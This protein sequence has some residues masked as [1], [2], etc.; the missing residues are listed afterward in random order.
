MEG[1]SAGEQMSRATEP[2]SRGSAGDRVRLRDPCRRSRPAC[3]SSPTAWSTATARS[4]PA[5]PRA[6]CGC[7]RLARMTEA[8]FSRE[9]AGDLRSA[10]LR[11]FQEEEIQVMLRF[12]ASLGEGI[13]ESSS[14]PIRLWRAT[15]TARRPYASPRAASTRC[16]GTWSAP[17]PSSAPS[18]PAPARDV[19]RRAAR[20]ERHREHRHPTGSPATVPLHT[21]LDRQSVPGRATQAPSGRR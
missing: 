1:N 17:S 14:N 16:A 19:R 12:A 10:F 6:G 2:R 13:A 20:M 11:D 7:V 21:A 9:P 4:W 15:T 8:E 18:A 5:G 3:A